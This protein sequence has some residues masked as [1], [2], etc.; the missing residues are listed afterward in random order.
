MFKI[1]GHSLTENGLRHASGPIQARQSIRYINLPEKV[2][3]NG[4]KEHFLGYQHKKNSLCGK[5]FTQ[6]L[7][8]YH[9]S[10]K[11]EQNLKGFLERLN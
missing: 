9:S 8:D 2:F 10:K 4:Q 11:F 5:L 1:F 7:K 3:Q 6:Q